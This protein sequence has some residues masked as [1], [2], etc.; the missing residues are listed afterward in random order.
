MGYSSHFPVPPQ[1]NDEI[2]PGYRQH[3]SVVCVSRHIS[4]LGRSLCG[5]T[6]IRVLNSDQL[7]VRHGNEVAEVSG[8]KNR[9]PVA[10]FDRGNAN[11]HVH[12]RRRANSPERP[13]Y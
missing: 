1:R 3:L 9:M 4:H 5:D 7:D 2:G 6:G 13:P 10:D 8:V 12:P 11:G